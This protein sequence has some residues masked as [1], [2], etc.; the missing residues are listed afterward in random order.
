MSDK[1]I[2]TSDY[3][4]FLKK[5]DL[6]QAVPAIKT[7]D[8]LTPGAYIVNYD[9]RKNFVMFQEMNLQCDKIV[10]LPGGEYE[11]IIQEIDIFLSPDASKRFEEVGLLP[12]NNILL[13]GIPGAGKTVIVNK[14][15]QKIIEQNGVVLFN[16]HP[17]AIPETYRIFDSIQPDTL[18]LVIME[19]LDSMV[20]DIGENPFLHFLDGEVQKK[21]AIYVATTNFLDRI[22]DRIRR[23][24]RFS[25][26][27]EIGM[28]KF[29]ARQ[30]YLNTK[31]KNLELAKSI[32]ASTDGFSIDMLKEVVRLHY[33][34]GKELEYS[35]ARVAGRQIIKNSGKK[36]HS[37]ACT[38]TVGGI[39][40]PVELGN[41]ESDYIT[42]SE[43]G[44]YDLEPEL[45]PEESEAEGT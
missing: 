34:L 39:T 30:F 26:V 40:I 38:I 41:S 36:S 25:V 32:A 14:L 22:P 17:T 19:E 23:P 5:D 20:K 10:D 21:N 43:V 35:I 37:G 1:H 27:K 7:Y 6:I 24:G 28:P 31:L 4:M 15:A 45:H 18:I 29:E 44:R 2:K 8:K 33:C 12:K 16:P 9:P 13:Y 11:E 42:T 3:A